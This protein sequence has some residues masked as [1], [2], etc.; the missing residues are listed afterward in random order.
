MRVASIAPRDERPEN[1]DFNATLA[2]LNSAT[3]AA[4][5]ALGWSV[6][7]VASGEHPIET[8]LDAADSADVIVVMGGED[9]SP[10]LYDGP[11]HY[12]EA[13]RRSR[14]SRHGTHRRDPARCCDRQAA[15]RHLPRQSAHQH[16]VR[17]HSRAAHADGKRPSRCGEFGRDS[18]TPAPIELLNIPHGLQSDVADEPVLHS[19]HQ[20]IDDLGEGLIVAAR[21]AD[22]TIE[23]VVHASAP[24]TG[25]QWHPEFPDTAA[26]QLTALLKRLER[27]AQQ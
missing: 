1:P 10:E 25:V 8:S 6:D 7:V 24:I 19:H 4:A 13:G 16:G 12:E 15:A 3:I 22:G 11:E 9:V 14:R 5:E 23:A 21:A 2:E 27:Q 26:K 18:F 20:A 17:R